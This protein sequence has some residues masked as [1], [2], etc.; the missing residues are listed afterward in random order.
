MDKTD[1]ARQAC[2]VPATRCAHVS[3]EFLTVKSVES[4]LTSSIQRLSP[5][6][7]GPELYKHYSLDY[8]ELCQSI[9]TERQ[10]LQRHLFHWPPRTKSREHQLIRCRF[11]FHLFPHRNYYD[12]YKYSQ[13]QQPHINLHQ[14]LEYWPRFLRYLLPSVHSTEDQFVD[15]LPIYYSLLNQA[16]HTIQFLSLLFL[17]LLL[18]QRQCSYCFQCPLRQ[19]QSYSPVHH[20]T[21]PFI[22]PSLVDWKHFSFENPVSLYSG[23]N[24]HVFP[25]AKGPTHF[26]S[27][28]GLTFHSTL[29]PFSNSVPQS[30]LYCHGSKYPVWPCHLNIKLSFYLRDET[31]SYEQDP[32][33]GRGEQSQVKSQHFPINRSAVHL[34]DKFRRSSQKWRGSAP[35]ILT[36]GGQNRMMVI[37][38]DWISIYLL[39]GLSSMR[40]QY[41]R[42]RKSPIKGFHCFFLRFL[43]DLSQHIEIA[44]INLCVFLSLCFKAFLRDI[45]FEHI[46]HHYLISLTIFLLQ[47]I[48]ASCFPY[49][50][51]YL[52]FCCFLFIFSSFLNFHFKSRHK[53]SSFGNC[54]PYSLLC[55]SRLSNPPLSSS[56]FQGNRFNIT[57]FIQRRPCSPCRNS[58]VGALFIDLP[59]QL[60]QQRKV[61][62]QWGVGNYR[63]ANPSCLSKLLL[64]L[65]WL[66]LVVSMS[67]GIPFV[68]DATKRS[69]LPLVLAEA[70]T[71]LRANKTQPVEFPPSLSQ[72]ENHLTK[73]INQP[74]LIANPMEGTGAAEVDREYDLPQTVAEPVDGSSTNRP[75]LPSTRASLIHTRPTPMQPYGPSTLFTY[76]GAVVAL[77]MLIVTIAFV[78]HTR[79]V[80][81]FACI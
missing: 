53:Q 73:S 68:E 54:F 16:L 9:R 30:F 62:K 60:L 47:S 11:H 7:K 3:V 22:S 63:P 38:M 48:Y 70:Q 12:T 1:V 2:T 39:D 19:F 21:D 59:K 44:A 43:F 27:I 25:V 58:W 64:L 18:D 45:L 74:Q 42:R 10:M 81:M 55:S 35:L 78:S 8:I 71:S 50:L 72:D 46:C 65:L 41:R 32:F 57:G 67:L 77:G 31:K 33:C 28:R 6:N 37:I 29:V 15:H 61:Q 14:R 20:A 66:P 75:D 23:Q 79:Y 56:H 26:V 80:V 13:K 40:W 34:V 69:T 36:L 5:T 17:L 51:D 49:A 76:I 4:E 24:L 52:S